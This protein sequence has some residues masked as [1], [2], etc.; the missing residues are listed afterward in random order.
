MLPHVDDRKKPKRYK[1]QANASAD[2][3]SVRFAEWMLDA[4][5][6]DLRWH[7]PGYSWERTNPPPGAQSASGRRKARNALDFD[8]DSEDDEDRS[9][10]RLRRKRRSELL[11]QQRSD[12]MAPPTPT[13]E[14][15]QTPGA[16]EAGQSEAPRDMGGGSSVPAGSQRRRAMLARM[17]GGSYQSA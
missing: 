5:D 3:S 12:A 16:G 2:P 9:A 7:P 10:D 8:S 1:R 14:S 17:N 4:L 11:R 13:V 15:I 6:E